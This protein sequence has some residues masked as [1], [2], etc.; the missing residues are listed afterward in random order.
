MSYLVSRSFFEIKMKQQKILEKKIKEENDKRYEEAIK[1][2]AELIE[3]VT[4]AIILNWDISKEDEELVSKYF[5][6]RNENPRIP[7]I[8]GLIKGRDEAVLRAKLTLEERA[9]S[10]SDIL[11]A[12]KLWNKE[13]SFS[14]ENINYNP[15]K[16]T[17]ASTLI[18]NAFKI[19]FEFIWRDQSY[20]CMNEF[21]LNNGMGKKKILDSLV[22]S[23][24]NETVTIFQSKYRGYQARKK[25]KQNIEDLNKEIIQENEKT[26]STN[27]LNQMICLILCQI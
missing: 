10:E 17:R 12:Y 23:S 6:R 5:Y 3:A 14:K 1:D 16:A 25:H 13:P 20:A 4:T 15:D 7:E 27:C 22:I 2:K 21:R 9:K 24:I 19:N 11:E 18:L 8:F 26:I